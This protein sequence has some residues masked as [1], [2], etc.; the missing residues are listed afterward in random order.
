MIDQTE[1]TCPMILDLVQQLEESCVRVY[2]HTHM[3]QET[4]VRESIN[5]AETETELGS[6]VHDIFQLTSFFIF[7]FMTRTHGVS[8]NLVEFH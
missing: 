1:I 8:I 4:Y 3:H 5:G 6:M 2:V 7:I